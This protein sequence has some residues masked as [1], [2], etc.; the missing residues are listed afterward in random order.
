MNVWK[1]SILTDI[2]IKPLHKSHPEECYRYT[3]PIMNSILGLFKKSSV[4]SEGMG[5]TENAQVQWSLAGRCLV[6]LLCWIKLGAS[7]QEAARKIKPGLIKERENHQLHSL[8][9]A[10][11]RMIF[12][13]ILHPKLSKLLDFGVL[14]R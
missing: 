4:S 11:H 12:T 13:L 5:V 1:A 7:S 14:N 6:A 9:E 2:C 8:M 3:T 10:L